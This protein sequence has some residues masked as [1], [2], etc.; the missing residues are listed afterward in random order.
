[1]MYSLPEAKEKLHQKTMLMASE[2]KTDMPEH[3]FLRLEEVLAD[4]VTEITGLERRKAERSEIKEILI[5][6]REGF[7]RMDERFEAVDKRFEAVDKRFEAVDKRFDD[8]I[9]QMDKRFDDLIHQMD[10]RFE[11]VDKRFEDM[12]KRFS[13]MQWIMLFGFSVMSA[14]IVVSNFLTK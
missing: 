2:F 5:E 6:M 9:H 4:F 12:N 8:L 10:K 3:F 13:T 11:A 14:S 7:R 1:M